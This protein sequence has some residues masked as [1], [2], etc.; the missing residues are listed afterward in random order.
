MIQ[1]INWYTS[2]SLKEA[3]QNNLK[4]DENNEEDDD[5]NIEDDY[6]EKSD[7]IYEEN[8]ENTI[9]DL[10]DIK[11]KINK[12]NIIIE[13]PEERDEKKYRKSSGKGKHF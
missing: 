10:D 8:E 9:K 2:I 13:E 1:F 5:E 4:L 3:L 7:E 11:P 12:D 6:K